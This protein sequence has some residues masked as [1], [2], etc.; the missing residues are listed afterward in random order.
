MSQTLLK[1]S[2]V[3]ILSKPDSIGPSVGNQSGV[4]GS[5]DSEDE[6]NIIDNDE[7]ETIGKKSTIARDV[8]FSPSSS[9]ISGLSRMSTIRK[10]Y[11]RLVIDIKH[12]TFF[13]LIEELKK[14]RDISEETI[15]G[16]SESRITP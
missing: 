14:Y 15:Q 9:G 12:Y 10:A 16:L 2:S 8:V 1:P 7:E 13:D 5:Q 6:S 3:P 4:K 11:Q